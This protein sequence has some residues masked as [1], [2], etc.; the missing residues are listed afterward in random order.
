MQIS[1]LK[2]NTRIFQL[3]R[4]WQTITRLLNRINQL[5]SAQFSFRSPKWENWSRILEQKRNLLRIFILFE[6]SKFDVQK[7]R[8]LV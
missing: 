1:C 3:K 2:D 6:D 7:F 5:G 8:N 4:I